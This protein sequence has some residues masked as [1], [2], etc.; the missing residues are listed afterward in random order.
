MVAMLDDSDEVRWTAEV[1]DGLVVTLTNALI[2]TV[3]TSC[4][5]CVM[6][7][8]IVTVLVVEA[9]HTDGD[10]VTVTVAVLLADAAPDTDGDGVTVTVAVVV[11]EVVVGV[12]LFVEVVRFPKIEH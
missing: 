10:G 4:G 6:V 2:V 7:T 3:S 9:A 11:M 12:V 8:V 5:D 1:D